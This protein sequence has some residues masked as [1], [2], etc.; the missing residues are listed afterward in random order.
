MAKRGNSSG[1]WGLGLALL[2]V[3]L[4]WLP[5]V[6]LLA[7]GTSVLGLVRAPAHGGWG[8]SLVGLGLGLVCLN[9][10]G[11]YWMGW[12]WLRKPLGGG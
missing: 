8:R 3:V 12:W 1:T 10:S 5:P 7:V 2:S 6:P 9:L 11:G 4:G